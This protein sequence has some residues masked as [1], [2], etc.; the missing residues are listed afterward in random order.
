MK[1]ILVS[2]I[3][4]I[5]NGERTLERA[6][7]SV[8]NQSRF[9]DLEIILIDDGSKDK[10]N[11]VAR[12]FCNDYPDNIFIYFNKT[13][14]GIAK[15]QN[16]GLKKARGKY[17]ARID[18]DDIWTDKSK[19]E[20][21][22][23]RLQNDSS[24]GLVGTWAMVVNENGPDFK[25][26]PPAEDSLIRKQ[27]LM[28]SMFV[29][30]SVMFRKDLTNRI[31]YYREDLKYGTEDYEYWLRIGAV[32]KLANIP[33]YC[34][35]YHFHMTSYSNQK[36]IQALQEHSQIIKGYA[37]DYPNFKIAYMKNIIQSNILKLKFARVIYDYLVPRIASRIYK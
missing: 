16:I 31:G 27:F 15:T 37:K 14:Q 29:S 22:L 6:I 24:I 35:E 20:K 13:N 36:K 4:P 34:M 8:V 30:P 28:A 7:F 32:A 9:K 25:L 26:S 5:Y 19:I 2:V 33:Y 3:L 12:K 23:E 11:E 18:Q 10:S 21:Q 1:K 17:I